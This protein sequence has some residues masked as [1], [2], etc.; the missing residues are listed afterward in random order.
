MKAEIIPNEPVIY[1][2]AIDLDEAEIYS[3]KDTLETV[4]S[5]GVKLTQGQSEDIQVILQALKRF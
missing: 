5:C 1:T 3:L 2:L 4:I